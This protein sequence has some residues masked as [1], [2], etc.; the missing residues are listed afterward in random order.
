MSTAERERRLSKLEGVT[1]WV[2]V[3]KGEEE[4]LGRSGGADDDLCAAAALL[5]SAAET[6]ARHLG[7]GPF[8][9]LE[10]ILPGAA[11]RVIP[12][13]D[14]YLGCRLTLPSEAEVGPRPRGEAAPVRTRT[15]TPTG[16]DRLLW[17]KVELVNMLVDEFASG[18]PK[19]PWLEFVRRVLST[20][21]PNA[22]VAGS[23][24]I[25]EEGVSV[26]G[27][28]AATVAEDDV[29]VI[30]KRVTD[31]LCQEAIRELGA[32]RARQHVHAVIGR[33]GL[34]GT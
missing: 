16:A 2:E 34:G 8:R 9:S 10:A 33:L 13:S 17:S 18:D 4:S 30:F 5:G 28:L 12:M 11:I 32:A 6:M 29:A 14:R 15:G 24:L 22:E 23:V 1:A 19:R 7:L 21:D 31:L 26:A 3:R 20:A 25:G 27:G